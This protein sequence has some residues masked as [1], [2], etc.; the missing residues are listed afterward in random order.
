MITATDCTLEATR[1]VWEDQYTDDTIDF[2]VGCLNDY[3]CDS[4][5]YYVK[6]IFDLLIY[7]LFL[8][9]VIGIFNYMV[10]AALTAY[11]NKMTTHRLVH[12][13]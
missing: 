13:L 1:Y 7:F 6:G 5:L 9:S 10:L 4:T 3:C 8:L 12:G 11:L 2:L